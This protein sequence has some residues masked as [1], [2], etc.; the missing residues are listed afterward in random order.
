MRIKKQFMAII[1]AVILIASSVL[2]YTTYVS[3]QEDRVGYIGIE[4]DK[5]T[6][7]SSE[8]VTFHLVSL[9]DNAKFNITDHWVDWGDEQYDGL[10]II[11]VPDSEDPDTFLDDQ[12]NLDYIHFQSS[13]YNT[14][15]KAHFNYFNSEDGSLQVTWNRTIRWDGMVEGNWTVVYHPAVSGYY[16]VAPRISWRAEEDNHVF[17]ID[18]KAI[19]YYDSLDTNITATNVPNT[20]VTIELTLQAPP[21]AVGNII[22]DLNT[23]LYYEANPFEY[24][25]EVTLYH[26]ETGIVLT[27]DQDRV[28][29]I[30]FNVS[31]PDHGYETPF[32]DEYDDNY[33]SVLSFDI[34]LTTSI[35]DYISG[36]EAEWDGG[37]EYNC[38]Y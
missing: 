35:G 22:C 30:I 13:Y 33:F 6:F 1:I 12:N 3:V 26:N 11:R 29:T 37:W 17:V 25:D 7:N 18:E 28:I 2:A 9:T 32:E 10:D 20:N 34:V 8:D 21:G 27:S 23:T 38:Q 16:V 15:G 4:V 24:M 14:V 31:V 5:K 36:F 19:F